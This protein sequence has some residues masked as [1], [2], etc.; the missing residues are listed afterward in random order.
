LGQ[1][2]LN[3]DA[4]LRVVELLL[5]WEGRVRNTRLRAILGIHFTT[6]SRLVA[7]YRELNPGAAD[8]EASTKSYVASPS[9]KAALTDGTVEEYLALVDCTRAGKDPVVRLMKDFSDLK[10][11]LFALLHRA[12]EERRGA[13]IVHGSMPNPKHGVREIWPHAL[14]RAGRRWHVRAWC[15]QAEQFR[16]F[17]L[18]R[19]HNACLL[20]AERPALADPQKDT[21]WQTFVDLRL[22]AHPELSREQQRLV[23]DE[24]FKGASA[25]GLTER[26]ALLPYLIHDLRASL[27]VSKERPPSFQLAVVDPSALASWLLPSEQAC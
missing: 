18:G 25:R 14:V 26:G 4:G 3:T 24:Y 21:A 27:D 2:R 20:D 7:A 13:H 11:P 22:I 6:A 23:Q 5:L 12:C 10:P 1:S 9:I 16:D 19:I 8:Y 15:V 17:S